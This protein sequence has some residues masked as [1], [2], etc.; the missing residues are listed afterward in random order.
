MAL[1][2]KHFALKYFPYIQ[3][4]H[5]RNETGIIGINEK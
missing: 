3:Q 1:L 5:K 4:A 2:L